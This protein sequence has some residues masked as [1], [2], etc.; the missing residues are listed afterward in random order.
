MAQQ[1]GVLAHAKSA[2]ANISNAFLLHVQ[3]PAMTYLPP[4]VREKS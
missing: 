1:Q 2:Y 3:A 4:V